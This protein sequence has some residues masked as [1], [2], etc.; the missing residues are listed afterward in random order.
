[1]QMEHNNS[2][3]LPFT[4]YKWQL[5]IIGVGLLVYFN[6]LFGSFVWDDIDQIV[7]N[8]AIHSVINIPSFFFGST[9]APQNSNSLGGLYYRP[10]M[11]AAFA[12]IYSVFGAQTFFFHALQLGLHIVNALL[13]FY[14]FKK[15]FK[16]YL[17]F[18]LSLIF[19][20]H[21]M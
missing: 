15:F 9:F 3:E 17:A 6:G 8:Y 2:L 5:I 11:S 7:N 1:M 18:F 4:Q 12:V 19:L 21:P 13:V 14:L 16:E 20:I 10:I